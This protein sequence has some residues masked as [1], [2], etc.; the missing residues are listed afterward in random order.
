[1][2]ESKDGHATEFINAV[3]SRFEHDVIDQQIIELLRKQGRLPY[4]CLARRLSLT[5]TMVRARVRRLEQ[6]DALRIVA[7]T[8]L[9][10]LG[11]GVMAVV[12]VQVVGR[13]IDAVAKD[14]AAFTDVVS[15]CQVIG[16]TDLELLL[17]AEDQQS[18][19]E[20]L[21]RQLAFVVGVGRLVPALAIDV[22]KNRFN[23]VPF[24]LDGTSRAPHGELL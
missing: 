18:L 21:F 4:R 19:Y 2:Q 17:V 14:L 22:A 23:W 8:D 1:M 13:A 11:Y 20:L 6:S 7:V 3:D 15:V 5:E 12:G 9:Y 16:A 10:A 24:H